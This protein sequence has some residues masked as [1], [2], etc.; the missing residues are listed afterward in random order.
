[1]SKWICSLSDH[2][3]M[4]CNYLGKLRCETAKD[5]DS[6]DDT[7]IHK[8]Y[9]EREKQNIIACMGELA[10]SKMLNANWSAMHWMKPDVG[11]YIEVRSVTEDWHNLIVRQPDKDS[12]P[13]VLVLVEN[14]ICMAKGWDFVSNIREKGVYSDEKGLPYWRTTKGHKFRDMNELLMRHLNYQKRLNNFD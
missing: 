3:M 1:M 11:G 10:V 7:G 14:N 13:M 2:E 5:D 6:T 9:S 12:S 4:V 8:S